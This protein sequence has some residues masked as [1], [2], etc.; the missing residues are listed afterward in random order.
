M[1][2]EL[3]KIYED[4]TN[5]F[6]LPVFDLFTWQNINTKYIDPDIS[7]PMSKRAKVMIDTLIH[8]LKNIILNFHLG[9]L[10]CMMFVK[11][12]MIYATST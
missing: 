7:L 2:E 9:N 10:I 3:L 5:E 12:F 6:G 4:N 8:F 1:N 11:T